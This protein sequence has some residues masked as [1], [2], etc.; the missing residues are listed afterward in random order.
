MAS[1]QEDFERK[2]TGRPELFR[3]MVQGVANHLGSG[4]KYTHFNTTKYF[5]KQLI[6][7]L[8][9]WHIILEVEQRGVN[10]DK[11][12]GLLPKRYLHDLGVANRL[13]SF[14][15]PEISIMETLDPL[16]RTPL[17]ALFENSLMIQLL[18]GES[19]FHTI[20]TWKKG[21]KVDIE[22][23]FIY[24]LPSR[25]CRVPIEC[26][27]ALLVKKKHYKNIIHYLKLTQQHVGVLI[28]AAPFK[29]IKN[30][31]YTIINIPIYLATKQNIAFYVDALL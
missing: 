3:E 26:K 29:I 18:N 30:E 28:S 23:D 10:P 12:G 25:N 1:L 13:R 17:G 2:E 22:V 27:A 16:L 14:P 4:S 8:K 7:A 5:A 9:K 24:D 21:G 11:G 15:A 20:T 19:A 6:C 31:T